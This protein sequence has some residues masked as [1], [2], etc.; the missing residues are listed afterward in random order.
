VFA[1]WA[2]GRRRKNL[3]TALPPEETDIQKASN[4]K[5]EKK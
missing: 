5:T 2:K 1:T 3:T 4:T